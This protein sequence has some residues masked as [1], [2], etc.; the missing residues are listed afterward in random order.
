MDLTMCGLL[1]GRAEEIARLYR[2]HGDWNQVEEIW[3]EE[4]RPPVRGCFCRQYL[5]DRPVVI[6]VHPAEYVIGPPDLVLDGIKHS[7]EFFEDIVV[8]VD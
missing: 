1:P 3:F 7:A 2:E 6:C 4:R 5:D 8:G